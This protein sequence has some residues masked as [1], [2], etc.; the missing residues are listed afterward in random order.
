[1]PH[2]NGLPVRAAS[3]GQTRLSR[4]H[5]PAVSFCHFLREIAQTSPPRLTQN[6][7]VSLWSGEHGA[8][9]H[10]TRISTLLCRYAGA[11]GAAGRTARSRRQV[12]CQLRRRRADAGI[13]FDD[14]HKAAGGSVITYIANVAERLNAGV[15][16]KAGSAGARD[17]GSD[18]LRQNKEGPPTGGVRASNRCSRETP[19]R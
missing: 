8:G 18:H 7:V 2:C 19:E 12:G 17:R 6:L 16:A 11:T 5:L 9:S 14:I 3:C 4:T 1:M 10:A 13:S 15:A